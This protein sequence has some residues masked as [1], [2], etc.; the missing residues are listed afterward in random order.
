MSA[1]TRWGH[2]NAGR[3][4]RTMFFHANATAGGAKPTSGNQHE[5]PPGDRPICAR[6]KIRTLHRPPRRA[7][8]VK[9]RTGIPPSN[10]QND[11]NLTNH[12]AGA[13]IQAKGFHARFFLWPRFFPSARPHRGPPG[14]APPF[15]CKTFNGQQSSP[16]PGSPELPSP[17]RP[18]PAPL[19]PPVYP[20]RVRPPTAVLGPR[21]PQALGMG[22]DE[23]RNEPSC[24]FSFPAPTYPGAWAESARL[25]TR[26][27][28]NNR[29]RRLRKP[30]STNNRPRNDV[31]HTRKVL[32][33]LRPTTFKP[34]VPLLDFRLP[35]R[36]PAVRGH[37]TAHGRFPT[38]TRGGNPS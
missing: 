15:G 2:N 35:T 27:A 20:V 36:R 34:S 13:C 7:L 17:R 1:T 5:T 9:T 14:P 29:P 4:K 30:S 21:P 8:F 10:I 19:S 37:R 33:G 22:D 18:P 12:H 26:P 3:Q 38:S 31:S 32:W 6:F 23:G 11:I 24:L 28:G 25:A 16:G